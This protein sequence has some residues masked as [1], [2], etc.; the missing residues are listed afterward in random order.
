MEKFVEGGHF[1]EGLRWHDGHWWASD[2]YGKCVLKITPEG[3]SVRVAEV[4]NQPSG[5]GWMPDGSLLI[6]S[7]LDRKVLRLRP[8]G[9]MTEHADLNPYTGGITNDM[10]VDA[11]GRAYVGNVGFD[12]FGGGKPKPATVVLVDV[13]GSCR[14]AAE[15]VKLPNGSVITPDG[16]TLIVGE[17]FGASLLAFTIEPDGS[18]R[19][20]RIWAQIDNPPR[21]DSLEMLMQVGFAPDGCDM[22]AQGNIWVADAF[23]GRCCRVAPGGKILETIEGPGGNGLYCCALGGKSGKTLLLAVA[24]DHHDHNRKAAKES[25]LYTVELP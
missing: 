23:H 24:P 16:K 5:L 8:D 18:L 22:D 11:K 1:F 20:R 19:D 2:V 3:R 12:L 9:R 7:M 25:V 17:T 15:D 10:V 4:P 14:I 6:S 13:D 21:W